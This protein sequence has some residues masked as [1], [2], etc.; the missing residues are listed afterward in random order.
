MA[1]SAVL[2]EALSSAT[3]NCTQL[4]WRRKR[5]PA[6]PYRAFPVLKERRNNLPSKFRVLNQLAV[7]PTCQPFPSADPK[8]PVARDQHPPN[9]SGGEMLT[10]R[11]LP[12]DA[13]NAIEAKQAEF[14]AQPDVTVG[15]LSKRDD[16]AFGKALA[17]PPRR[18]R[19]LADVK[20]GVQGR[21]AT[22]AC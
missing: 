10:R 8:R 20:R 22:A 3:V 18:V 21:S 2:P 11:R 19:V 5:Q 9:I 1:K 6:G 13:P 15:R 16:T 7:L 17:N 14:C 4:P 12:G